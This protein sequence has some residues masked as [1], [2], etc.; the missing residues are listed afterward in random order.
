MYAEFRDF[1]P[2]PWWSW[3]G[4]LKKPEMLRQ[5][6]MIKNAGV[7]EFFIY[8]II[9][10]EYPRFLEDSWFDYVGFILKE[11]EKRNMHPT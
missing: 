4:N 3:T 11:A 6:D 5:L 9:G 8:A 7:D 10:L 2:V 1:G